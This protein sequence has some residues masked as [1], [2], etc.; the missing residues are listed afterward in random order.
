MEEAKQI[1]EKQIYKIKELL[2][3]I[4]QKLLFREYIYILLK[5]KVNKKLKSTSQVQNTFTKTCVKPYK[6]SYG[7][8][9]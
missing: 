7:Q 4:I 3:R 5:I 9:L 1:Q 6:F 2:V 8:K